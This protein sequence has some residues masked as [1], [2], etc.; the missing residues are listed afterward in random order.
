[1]H[2]VT[3]HDNET[4]SERIH[5]TATGSVA[6]AFARKM[7]NHYNDSRVT[8]TGSRVTVTD[9]DGNTVEIREKGW[10]RA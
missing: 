5:T 6:H 4:G 10:S 8:V 2:T 7:H 1:M 9:P 3:I